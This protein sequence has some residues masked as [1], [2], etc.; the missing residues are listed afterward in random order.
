MKEIEQK[1]L[2]LHAEARAQD[3]VVG[4]NHELQKARDEIA[5]RRPQI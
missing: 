3:K 4:V 2:S 5:G 1:M